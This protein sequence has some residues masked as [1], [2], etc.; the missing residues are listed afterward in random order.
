[1]ANWHYAQGGQQL[2]PVS[3]ETLQGLAHSGQLRP[4]D[5]VWNDT[6]PQWT[7]AGQIPQIIGG[8]A[9]PPQATPGYG[10]YQ[11]QSAA[12]SLSYSTG[13]VMAT[14]RAMD[15]LRQTKPWARLM[16]VVAIVMSG[17]I[18]VLG[19]ALIG[20]SGANPRVFGPMAGVGAIGGVIY[21]GLGAIYIIPGIFLNRYATLI[22]TALRSN[23]SEDLEGALQAQKSFWK[24]V[25]I[26]T[27]IILSIYVL[28]F[29]FAMLGLLMR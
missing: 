13:G 5:L 28:I 21:I 19:L 22:G 23:R 26:F 20:M 17:L 29:I 12:Q 10:G 6:L 15:L 16:G 2:G 11:S 14:A 7:P 8:A 9:A 27:T 25:G 1:M 18:M 4:T 3:L 24:F